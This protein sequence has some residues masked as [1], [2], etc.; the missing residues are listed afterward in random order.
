MARQM[1]ARRG[2]AVSVSPASRHLPAAPTM[3]VPIVAATIA[4]EPLDPASMLLRNS[5]SSLGAGLVNCGTR[6][7]LVTVRAGDT[8]RGSERGRREHRQ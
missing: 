6:D 7:L 8:P 2:K 5:T 4:P 1:S 3:W